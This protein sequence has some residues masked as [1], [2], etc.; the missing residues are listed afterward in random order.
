MSQKKDTLILLLS[1]LITLGVL[2]GGGFWLFEQISTRHNL[3]NSTKTEEKKPSQSSLQFS[4]GE[5]ILIPEN[6][7]PAKQ[8]G[9]AALAVKNYGEAV[10]QLSLSLQQNPN[11]PEALIYLNNARITNNKSYSIAVSVPIGVEVNA[12]KEILRGVAQAQN[13]I[14]RAAGIN[15]VP[16]KVIMAND[17]NNPGI[18]A[19]L[20]ENFA[21]NPDILGVVGHF[22]SNVTLAAAKVYQEKG[23]VVIS[24]TS[25]SVQLSGISKYLFRTVPS[26][27]FAGNALSRYMLEKLK[28]K[29]AA[30]FFNSASSY[31]TSLKDVFTTSTFA[32]GGEIVAEF[33]FAS[34][35]YNSAEA[36]QEAR[37]KQAQALMLAPNSA[38]LDQALQVV[39][40]NNAQLPMLGGD[41]VYKPK[42]LQIGGA[43]AVG[44]ILAVPWHILADPNSPFPR[45]ASQLWGGDVN[46][47]TALAYDATKALIEAI[48]QNPSRQGV[49]QALS[50][51]TFTAMGASAEIRFLASGDRN[52]SVQLVKILPGTRSGFGYD[53]VPEKN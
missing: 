52:R 32:D 35:N 39:Q 18:A 50:A 43:D 40:V 1:L 51:P 20:A 36:L 4:T 8:A 3:G 6:L 16:L 46:W 14:N 23:L 29:K 34:P 27:R 22:G 10:K 11:D 41:S 5:S 49:Q 28:L 45:A 31:S 13:E 21:N 7:N 19:R 42:T 37:Q 25:T 17:D 24:P 38:T 26:D 48:S 30:V 47:R 33:D 53:F 9:V 15:G 44:M 2:G 12:A